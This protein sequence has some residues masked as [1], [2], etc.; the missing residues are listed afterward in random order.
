MLT[1][2]AGTYRRPW[3]EASAGGPTRWHSRGPTLF[4][5][6]Y[7]YFTTVAAPTGVVGGHGGSMDLARAHPYCALR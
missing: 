5:A 1:I 4:D 3:G 7:S 2:L 6:P